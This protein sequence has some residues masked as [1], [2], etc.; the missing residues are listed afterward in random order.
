MTESKK[1]YASL[2]DLVRENPKFDEKCRAYS[3][4]HGG[5]IEFV[6]SNSQGNAALQI[7]EVETITQKQ[8]L[9]AFIENAT[10]KQDGDKKTA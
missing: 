4:K 9:N 2:V 5:K 10:K 1:R 8:L 6:V 3:V 7:C